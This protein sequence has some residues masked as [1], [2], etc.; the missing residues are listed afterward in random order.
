[1]TEMAAKAGFLVKFGPAT[2]PCANGINE[3]N[4]AT[5]D[6]IVQ[7]IIDLD[8]T[9]TLEQAVAMAAWTHN[10]NVNKLGYSPLQLVTGKA[11][12]I[13]GLTMGDEATD[14]QFDSEDNG[15]TFCYFERVCL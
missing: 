6:K 14:S 7:K 15:E 9:I 10:S 4:H 3:C 8:L 5:A 11:V 13:P 2:S 12:N 1:M